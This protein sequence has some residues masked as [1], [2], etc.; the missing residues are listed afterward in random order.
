MYRSERWTIKKVEHWRI[1]G[2]ELWCWKRLLRVL[3]TARR[4]NQSILRKSALNIHGKDWCWSWNSNTLATWREELTH[5]KRPWCWERVKAGRDGNDRGW[6]GWMA[7]LMQ[8]TWVWENSGRLWR[9]GKPGM[10]QS[11]GSQRAG[12][13]WATEQQKSLSSQKALCHSFLISTDASSP[14]P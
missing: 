11:M 8:W 5:F 10:L 1:D 14:T 2:F 4:S 9:T 3:W 12:H 6:D 13:D 7:S